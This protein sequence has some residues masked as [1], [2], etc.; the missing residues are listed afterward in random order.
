MRPPPLHWIILEA[1]GASDL[2]SNPSTGVS[3]DRRPSSAEPNQDLGESHRGKAPRCKL[4]NRGAYEVARKP[5]RASRTSQRPVGSGGFD[6]PP[7]RSPSTFGRDPSGDSRVR[8][9]PA[10]GVTL[11]RCRL[12][13]GKRP[14]RS[15]PRSAFPKPP[16]QCGPGIRQSMARV[17]AH[18]TRRKNRPSLGGLSVEQE[19]RSCSYRCP[20][21]SFR[22]HRRGGVG[23]SR[24][25]TISDRRADG[26]AA[27][28]RTSGI[29]GRLREGAARRGH[30]ASLRIGNRIRAPFAG[31][32]R[33]SE[34]HTPAKSHRFL[35][36][37]YLDD[38]R[39]V[40]RDDRRTSTLPETR[41]PHRRNGGSRRVY[42]R[43]AARGTCR[44]S[45]RDQ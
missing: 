24:R 16:P 18:K 36:G 12:I 31:P 13:S 43:S 6:L 20:R 8:P 42:R 22:R 4:G 29:P 35:R 19:G 39:A 37:T 2:G 40:S 27:S 21:G 14:K 1:C 32:R 44:R 28:E 38:G 23:R 41:H 33:A 5:L 15:R 30:F 25:E 3:C 34:G 10:R 7:R 9:T 45:I 26:I 17:L 11:E